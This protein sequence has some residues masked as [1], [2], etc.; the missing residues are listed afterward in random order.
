[1]KKTDARKQTRD[2]LHERRKQVIR[3]YEEGVPVMQIV[4]RTG[5]SW[6]AVNAAI[7]LYQAGGLSALKPAARGRKKGTG[8][9]LTNAQ[10]ADIRLMIRMRRPWFYKLKDSSWNRQTVKQLIDKKCGVTLSV[11]G[12]GNYLDRWGLTLKKPNARPYERCSREIRAW[13]DKHY[14][15][16][17]QQARA[18]KAEIYWMNAPT[19][20]SNNS[21]RRIDAP[22]DK[23]SKAAAEVRKRQR[24]W[25][26]S[27]VTN[28]G[29]VRWVTFKGTFNTRR[30][31]NFMEALIK[32]TENKMLFLIR[33]DYDAY[34]SQQF[35]AWAFG[36]RRRF[37]VFPDYMELALM[38]L[39]QK[40]K[41]R[42]PINLPPVGG[43]GRAPP[44][45]ERQ[46]HRWVIQLK[47]R[48][49]PT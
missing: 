21:W 49:E 34:R 35:M 12:V 16:I 46:G 23:P 39:A 40:V 41:S 22:N 33:S 24:L 30:Q 32:D 10:E 17:E 29:K 9:I 4:K 28:E 27:V 15:Q 2:E 6:T 48:G 11:R 44:R 3:L 25:M 14:A 37:R 31:I 18:W 43:K 13:L 20:I 26:L 36:H 47:K 5:L 1:M 45:K 7:K 42:L 38:K 8:R 19:M